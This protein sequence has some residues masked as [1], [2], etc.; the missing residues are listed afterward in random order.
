[1]N[2]EGFLAQ[3]E[4]LLTGISEEERA[5][6]LQYY[7]DYFE[8]AGPE[9]EEQVIKELGS[10]EKVAAMIRADLKGNREET[11]EF[12]EYGYTDERFEEKESPACRETKDTKHRYFRRERE[13]ENRYSYHEGGADTGSYAYGTSSYQDTGSASGKN[14]PRTSRWLKVLLVILIILVAVP[15]AVPIV[16]AAVAVVIGI[17]CAVIGIFAGLAVG[18]LAVAAAGFCVVI[19]GLIQ[20]AAIPPAALLTVGI[21]MLI[22]VVGIILTAVTV[23][24]C[25][26]MYPAMFRAAVN[27]CRRPFHRKVVS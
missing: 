27:L 8:D 19:A 7:E 14:R 16:I 3:L 17:V 26:V 12:T 13:T 10:P 18:A 11:G 4:N 24:L 5:E 15:T 2:R 23:K 9:Q 6:A 25:I 1:M 20:L 21:G 22:L